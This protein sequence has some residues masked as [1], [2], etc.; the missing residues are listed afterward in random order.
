MLSRA[1]T[2]IKLFF[3]YLLVFLPCTPKIGELEQGDCIFVQAFGRNSIPDEELGKTVREK[4]SKDETLNQRLKSLNDDDFDPG[5][6][7]KALAKKALRLAKRRDIPV[8]SQWEVVYAIWELDRQW[9]LDNQSKI[10]CLWPPEEGY[11]T[12]FDVKQECKKR[13]KQ[14]G[15][16]KPIEICH[17]AM[18]ARATA[19]IWKTGT[20]LVT[21]GI[22]PWS[23]SKN[24]LWVWDSSSIQPW[25]REFVPL[26]ALRNGWWL[27]KD[28]KERILKGIWWIRE[29]SVRFLH[30]PLKG[31]VTFIPPK[32]S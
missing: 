26:E 15:K 13:M 5:K 23:F 1:W 20:D 2:G 31:W 14:R 22:K 3:C 10:D 11:Y 17:P 9:L 6:S 24:E 4:I 7:N 21:E 27:L 29:G 19:I 18:A 16:S 32:N 12:T 30:H 28:P 8:I 25:T